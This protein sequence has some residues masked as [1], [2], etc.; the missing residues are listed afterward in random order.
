MV[1]GFEGSLEYIQHDYDHLT[2]IL[3]G[4][5]LAVE[6]T[7]RGRMS[8]K[9]WA[10]GETPGGT[11][12]QPLQVFKMAEYRACTSISIPTMQVKMRRGFV[13]VRIVSG[14]G[15]WA[16]PSNRALRVLCKSN[17]SRRV[18]LKRYLLM[19]IEDGPDV[20]KR[21]NEKHVTR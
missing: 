7:S 21:N 12:L 19:R 11:F 6:G 8:G 10:G 5:Y 2:F 1:K 3:S 13:G 18:G 15:R 20:Q 14:K 17:N 9:S 4:D 16:F